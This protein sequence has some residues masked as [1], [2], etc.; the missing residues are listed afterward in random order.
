MLIETKR[1]VLRPVCESDDE[2]IFEYSKNPNV[3]PNA[4]WKPHESVAETRELMKAVFVKA[5]GVFAIVLKE[6]GKLIGSV[7]IISD[8]KREYDGARMLG[9]AIGEEYWG[10]G[11]M[12]EAA[13][14]VIEYGFEELKLDLISA[15]CF[16]FNKRSK[17]VLE[18]HGFTYEG[19]LTKCEKRFDGLLLDNECY[20][21]TAENFRAGRNENTASDF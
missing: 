1:L 8:P 11:Y 20:A 13:G 15:Y 6:S 18:K 12:T 2:A 21:L 3:G 16:P 7:G 4:G 19:T 17:R 10:K 5:D 9:Y 14:A